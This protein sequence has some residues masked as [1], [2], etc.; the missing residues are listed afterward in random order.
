MILNNHL[1]QHFFVYN[2]KKN[3]QTQ[4]RGTIQMNRTPTIDLEPFKKESWKSS[5]TQLNQD[6]L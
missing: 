4:R 2:K 3:L 5:N 6:S 1:R